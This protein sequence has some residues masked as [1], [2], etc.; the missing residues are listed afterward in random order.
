MQS[1]YCHPWHGFQVVSVILVFKYSLW[2]MMDIREL[3]RKDPTSWVFINLNLCLSFLLYYVHHL[4]FG[5]MILV[6]ILK[7]LIKLYCNL[8]LTSL[9]EN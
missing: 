2:S 3:T 4:H 1:I 5:N 7:L 8:F 6:Q 9:I